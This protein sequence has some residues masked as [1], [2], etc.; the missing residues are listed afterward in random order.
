LVNCGG[1]DESDSSDNSSQQNNVTISGTTI[2]LTLDTED[3]IF[4]Q[5]VIEWNDGN[6]LSYLVNNK[7]VVTYL[8]GS[9]YSSHSV[10]DGYWDVR[11]DNNELW[12]LFK[13]G[14]LYRFEVTTDGNK[15]IQYITR[16]N[17]DAQLTHLIEE[18]SESLLEKIAQDKA[19]END[20]I[21]VKN[22]VSLQDLI[23]EWAIISTNIYDQE[24]GSVYVL[25][26]D[27]NDY[28]G[29]MKSYQ[30]SRGIFARDNVTSITWK[31]K[32]DRKTISL[33]HWTED[34]IS[35]IDYTWTVQSLNTTTGEF[36]ITRK[37]D[38]FDSSGTQVLHKCGSLTASFER[39]KQLC[40]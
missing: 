17:S 32:S 7:Q 2:P 28:N 20:P 19:V 16:I 11:N 13:D 12:I 6:T 8:S 24:I 36:T 21:F 31:L 10:M 39:I 23:G 5:K 4:S 18:P 3:K 15:Y 22:S 26:S 29:K 1:D 38:G 34:K 14:N 37:I 25:T 33:R 35:Y 40:D 9:G 27:D 30:S